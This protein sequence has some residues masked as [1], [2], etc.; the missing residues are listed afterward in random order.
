MLWLPQLLHSPPDLWDVSEIAGWFEKAPHLHSQP[1]CLTPQLL[2]HSPRWSDLLA[3]KINAYY[4]EILAAY[5]GW[6][7]RVSTDTRMAMSLVDKLLAADLKGLSHEID[8]KNFD[9]I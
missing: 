5:S 9:Q 2:R 3:A 4:S 6:G 7:V 1:A 8:L